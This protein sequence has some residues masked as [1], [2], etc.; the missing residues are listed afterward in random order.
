MTVR[1]AAATAAVAV[2]V[3]ASCSA[4]PPA[5]QAGSPARTQ[6]AKPAARSFAPVNRSQLGG[7]VPMKCGQDETPWGYVAAVR[8]GEAAV[9]AA[10]LGRALLGQV[11]DR[12]TGLT[13]DIV[14]L[15]AVSRHFRAFF[16]AWRLAYPQAKQPQLLSCNY[17]LADSP[18]DQPIINAAIKAMVKAGYARSAAQVRSALQI[19]TVSDNPL[20][21]GQVIVTL[22]FGGPGHKL[23]NGPTVHSLVCDTVLEL[24]PGATV[25]GVARGGFD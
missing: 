23:P 11:T 8:P 7:A 9:A 25:T 6:A 18:A 10:A 13:L 2:T 15:A 17:L 3:L 5:G 14:G 21:A 12:Q 16:T 1:W 20:I 19:V 24:W 4:A 22:M